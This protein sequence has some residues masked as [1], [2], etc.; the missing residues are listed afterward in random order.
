M[1]KRLGRCK[2][3]D[4]GGSEETTTV[5][6]VRVGGGF[7]QTRTIKMV[8]V[9]STECAPELNVQCEKEESRMMPE[10]FA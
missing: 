9:S 2:S 5:T 3:R 4:R 6:E 10:A 7:N 1:Q 8:K